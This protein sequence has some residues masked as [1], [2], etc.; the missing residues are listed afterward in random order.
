MIQQ[1]PLVEK[2]GDKIGHYKNKLK[3][4]FKKK[5]ENYHTPSF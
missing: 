1:F 4:G 2:K 5:I 3:V